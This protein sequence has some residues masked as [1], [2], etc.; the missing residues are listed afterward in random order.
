MASTPSKNGIFRINDASGTPRDF[1]CNLTSF[2]RRNSRNVD[3][4]ETYC[5]VEKAPSA[6]DISYNGNAV[7]EG[8]A[9]EIGPV[10]EEL[11]DKSDA[12]SFYEWF[13]KGL[14]AGFPRYFGSGYLTAW[15]MDAA[16]PGNVLCDFTV[17]S[18][19][20]TLGVSS[21]S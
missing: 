1:T 5:T 10:M 13:P 15:N 2:N 14:T 17:E 21:G 16:N 3:K 8:D 12:P 20:D 19:S 18:V 11:S 9:D 7:W 4:V 6:R